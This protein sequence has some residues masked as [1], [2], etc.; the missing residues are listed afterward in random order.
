M[1]IGVTVIVWGLNI[2]GADGMPMLQNIMLGVHVA[3]F[4]GVVVVFWVLSPRADARV[5]FL[6]FGNEGG[7]ETV[8]LA[9]MVGQIS[10][11]YACICESARLFLFACDGY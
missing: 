8:G 9:V 10:A 6:E 4:L 11:V 1:V 7:W 2:W 3:G 5:T